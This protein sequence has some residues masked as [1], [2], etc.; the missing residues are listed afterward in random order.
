M[1]N[2]WEKAISILVG[3]LNSGCS[4]LIA[5]VNKNL[6]EKWAYVQDD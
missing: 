6:W 5:T 3:N 4:Y 2:I 1:T